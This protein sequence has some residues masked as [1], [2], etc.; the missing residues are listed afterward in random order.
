VN[1][2]FV[3]P[4]Y[5]PQ[6]GGVATYV[7]D[8]KRLLSARGHCIHVLCPGDS[9]VVQERSS[10]SDE[11]VVELNLRAPWI[12]TVP[13]KGVV[14][15][16]V[17]LIPTL[18]RLHRFMA[19]NKIQLV[20]LEYPLSCMIYFFILRMWTGIPIVVGLHGSDV[21]LLHTNDSVSQ[22]ILRGIVRRADWVL[23]HSV[24]LLADARVKVGKLRENCSYLHYGVECSRLRETA[25]TATAS[26]PIPDGDYVLTVAKLYPRKGLDVL[27]R[28]IHLLKQSHQGFRFVIVGDGPEEDRLKNMATELGIASMVVFA[29]DVKNDVVPALFKRCAFFALSSRVEPFGIVLLE[30]MTFGKAIVAT[31][32]GG[33][34]EFVQDGHNGLLIPVEDHQALAE[35]IQ[36]LLVD[37]ELRE[38]IGRNG[39]MVV[40]E[41]YDYDKLII[42]YEELF[43]EQMR[44]VDVG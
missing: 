33:I 13:V 36:K 19:K 32:A 5:A 7:Q 3:T 20:S 34:P 21:L 18:W 10:R 16:L 8:I 39:R 35:C 43:K 9:E 27:L 28:A 38:R 17:Y 2:L 1:I 22:R 23:A 25:E 11:G 30:A 31:T 37:K 44:R 15:F 4:F 41:Q 42:R 6:S 29:G 12:P 14:A 26:A 24:S 40:E